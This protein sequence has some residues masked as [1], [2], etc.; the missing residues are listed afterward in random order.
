MVNIVVFICSWI[1]NIKLNRFGGI[2]LGADRFK[3]IN[4]CCRQILNQNGYVDAKQKL[5][6]KL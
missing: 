4:D 3:H 6:T 5:Q 2:Q 1:L